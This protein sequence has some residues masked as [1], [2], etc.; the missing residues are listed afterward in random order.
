MKNAGRPM[1]NASVGSVPAEN[2]ALHFFIGMEQAGALG[3]ARRRPQVKARNNERHASD[4]RESR[5]STS[6]PFAA[7]V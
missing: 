5:Q 6:L 1:E 3:A 7:N 4:W 2:S